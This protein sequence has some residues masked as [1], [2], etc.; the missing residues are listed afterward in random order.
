M[1]WAHERRTKDCLDAA[2]KIGPE[3]AKRIYAEENYLRYGVVAAC[4]TSPEEFRK[5]LEKRAAEDLR[6]KHGKR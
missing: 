5:Y 3:E 6:A 1:A 4:R 2:R